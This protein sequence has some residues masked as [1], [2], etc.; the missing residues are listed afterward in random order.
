MRYDYVYDI[1]V[2]DIFPL[3][4]AEK[5]VLSGWLRY[6]DLGGAL[7]EFPNKNSK[8]TKVMFWDRD[9]KTFFSASAQRP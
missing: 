6:K 4:D 2:D 3:S 5:E 9:L 1:W 8:N 7:W